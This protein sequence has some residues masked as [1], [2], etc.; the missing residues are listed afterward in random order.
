MVQIKI[1]D[2]FNLLKFEYTII[3]SCEAHDLLES[4]HF[5]KA[6]FVRTIIQLANIVILQ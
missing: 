4:N 3:I 2:A 5:I 6:L 1:D